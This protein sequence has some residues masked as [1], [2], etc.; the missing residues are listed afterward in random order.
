MNNNL[1]QYLLPSLLKKCY[2]CEEYKYGS[3]ESWPLEPLGNIH[4]CN[5]EFLP[6]SRYTKYVV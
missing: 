3:D 1:V 5:I 6:T 2:T 4:I